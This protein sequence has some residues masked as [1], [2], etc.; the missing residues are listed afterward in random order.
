MEELPP[1][2]QIA[3]TTQLDVAIPGWH[4]NGH[5]EVYML[6]TLVAYFGL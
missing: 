5:G 3:E 1:E 2:L 6:N 4:I